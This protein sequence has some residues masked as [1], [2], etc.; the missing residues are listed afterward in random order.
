[1]FLARKDPSVMDQVECHVKM[2]IALYQTG[3]MDSE[4]ANTRLKWAQV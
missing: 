4:D 3:W 2:M 1:M